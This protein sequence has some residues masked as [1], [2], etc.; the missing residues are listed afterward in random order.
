MFHKALFP[1]KEATFGSNGFLKQKSDYEKP[2]RPMK[3]SNKHT[4]AADLPPDSASKTTG[5]NQPLPQAILARA[6]QLRAEVP[7]A[8]VSLDEMT[9]M[10]IYGRK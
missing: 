5:L 1:R 7:Y 6:L 8:A 3:K 9:A 10:K 2:S 4:Q